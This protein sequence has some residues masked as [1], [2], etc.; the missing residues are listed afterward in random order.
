MEFKE[1]SS[2]LVAI[3]DHLESTKDWVSVIDIAAETCISRSTVRS[4]IRKLLGLGIVN[5]ARLYPGFRYRFSEKAKLQPFWVRIEEARAGFNLR[6]TRTPS[7]TL[8]G[9]KAA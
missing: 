3:I 2:Q 8:L 6:T 1:I 9:E 5:I 4:H 7:S